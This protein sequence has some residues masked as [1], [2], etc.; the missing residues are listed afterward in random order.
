ALL[1]PQAYVGAA[2]EVAFTMAHTAAY[3]VTLAAAGRQ[4][5]DPAPPQSGDAGSPARPAPV[6]LVHGYLLNRGVFL[7]L[8]GALRRAGFGH[9]RSF[10]YPQQRWSLPEIAGRLGREVDRAVGDRAAARCMIVAHS[11]GGIAARYYIQH[12]GGDARVDTLVTLATPHRGTYAA[13]LAVG[14][15]AEQMYW[16]SA[17]MRDLEQTARPG[18][19][20]YVSYYTDLDAC[21]VPADS[22]KLTTPALQAVNIRVRDTGHMS[23]LGSDQVIRSVVGYL[24]RPEL[25]RPRPVAA[26]AGLAS[27]QRRSMGT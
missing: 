12:L 10:D 9:V 26:G 24:S 5:D 3:P 22:A 23:M 20:R 13:G 8:S 27:P 15:A 1:R 4:L 7:R 16:E 6:V 19:V 25:D 18:P 17:F 14:P 2:V 21:V 11:M